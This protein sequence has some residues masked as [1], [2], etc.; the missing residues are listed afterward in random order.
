MCAV[1]F[2]TFCS[3]LS[4]VSNRSSLG[5]GFFLALTEIISFVEKNRFRPVHSLSE[6]VCRGIA[7]VLTEQKVVM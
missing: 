5:L 4:E 3:W 6:L 7:E 1:L 2:A